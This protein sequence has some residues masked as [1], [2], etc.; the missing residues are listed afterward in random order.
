MSVEEKVLIEGITDSIPSI[1]SPVGPVGKSDRHADDIPH[2]AEP[3]LRVLSVTNMYPTPKW[4]A[5]GTFVFNEVK[6]LRAAGV[7]VDVL[8][9]NGRDSRWSY[10]RGLFHLWR[11][12]ARRKYDVIHA[13]YVLTGAVARLQWGTPVVLTH[14]GCEVLGYPRWQTWLAKAINPVF[15]EVIYRSEEM[16]QALNDEDGWILPAGIDLDRFRPTSR[17]AARAALGLP[18]DRPLV[19]W[20]GEPWRPEKR[21]PLAAEAVE[22]VKLDLTDAELVVLNKKP[23]DVVPLYMSACDALV[24]TSV[25]EGSPNVVKEAMACN[26]P[27]VSARVGDVPEVIA[28]TDGC[29]LAERDPADIARKLVPV[30]RN[31]RR[32]DGRLQVQ[33]FSHEQ[34]AAGI[35]RAYRRAASGANRARARHADA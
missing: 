13:H 22:L 30:L 25:L 17:D 4:P 15:D 10:L 5:F 33:R 27:V 12:L 20:A 7:S 32:T 9:M 26:L 28:G 21:F 3:R 18:L 8:V 1:R 19:L 29:T 16:R 23:H 2:E 24:F 14:H 11:A 6:S 35:A 31:P 34:I